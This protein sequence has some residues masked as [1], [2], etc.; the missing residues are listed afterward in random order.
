MHDFTPLNAS[1]GEVAALI[2]QMRRQEDAHRRVLAEQALLQAE[3]ARLQTV[4]TQRET[5]L[6]H[7]ECRNQALIFELAH[8][9]R[10]RYGV[11]SEALNAHQ[12]ALFEEGLEADIAACEARIEQEQPELIRPHRTR[13]GRQ[14]LPEHLPRIEHR[15]EPA[16]CH[17][18]QCGQTLVKIGEDISEQLDVEPARFF[19]HR[20]IRP[21]YACRHCETVTAAPI[22]PAIID[23]G[24]AAPGLLAWVAISKY[25]DH[26]PLHRLMQIA[27]RDGVTLSISTLAQWIGRVG[28][29]LQPLADRLTER[30]RQ[31]R[32]LHADETP[33]E[34]L[35]PGSGKTLKA[36][37][38]AYRS[39]PMSADPP[40]IVFDDQTGRAGHHA[41]AFL[42]GWQGQLMVDDYGGYKALFRE[43]RV[44]ELACMAHARRTFHELHKAQAHPIAF[45][46]LQ[47]IARIYAIEQ[48][49]RELD[50]AARAAL[51]RDE[52][53]PLLAEFK[54]WLDS[55]RLSV[56]S[57][58]AIAKAIDY[59]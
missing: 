44:I 56:A 10:L 9:R 46:A 30:L 55:T 32:I 2:E 23:G 22:P 39:T 35:D 27:A 18:G 13:A 53:Q 50:I 31:Q 37:L 17:C 6:K 5:A 34:Q 16:F 20:H 4:L 58:S 25:A 8:L 47:H 49:G 40:I 28:V 14:P 59:S 3:H 51:R 52:A 36:Y 45:E 33:V 24:L 1:S 43:G 19:V 15:H 38:W 26:L 12:R 57:N 11:K 54:A 42:D 48:R 21:Q 7:A 29:A 41:R